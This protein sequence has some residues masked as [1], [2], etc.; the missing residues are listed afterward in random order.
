MRYAITDGI[1][2]MQALM[3]PMTAP[4]GYSRPPASKSGHETQA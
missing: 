3:P 2:T 4:R 1:I